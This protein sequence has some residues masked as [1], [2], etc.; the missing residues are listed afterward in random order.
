MLNYMTFPIY[1]LNFTKKLKEI[2]LL[3]PALF[4]VKSEKLMPEITDYFQ[5]LLSS[6]NERYNSVLSETDTIQLK[7]KIM[8]LSI[9]EKID[10]CIFFKIKSHFNPSLT[11][12][13]RGFCKVLGLNNNLTLNGLLKNL[14]NINNLPLDKLKY[15]IKVPC[16][17][18][19]KLIEVEV[20]YWGS[21]KYSNNILHCSNCNHE[22]IFEISKYENDRRG[23]NSFRGLATQYCNCNS[24]NEWR[25][26]L[27]KYINEGIDS[28]EEEL[29]DEIYNNYTNETG[30]FNVL[31]LEQLYKIHKNSLTKTENE[32]L[33]LNPSNFNEMDT[34]LNEMNSRYKK[35]SKSKTVSNLFSHGIIY[36]EINPNMLKREITKYSNGYR[37][38]VNAIESN[39]ISQLYYG[40]MGVNL[41]EVSSPYSI[42]YITN[43]YFKY[44]NF[45][46]IDI[47]SITDYKLNK[48]YFQ[49]SDS[50]I[51]K[52]EYNIFNS[53]AECTLF[54]QLYRQYSNYIICPNISLKTFVN[55]DELSSAFSKDEMRYLKYCIIDFAISDLDGFVV[56]CIELQKGEHH[57]EKEW[58]YKDSLKKRCF[59]F[60][61]IEFAYEY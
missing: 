18:C 28:F 21:D 56:K 33:S 44:V 4:L 42:D 23:Y 36:E 22:F 52:K 13:I 39:E 3:Q 15:N 45:C 60:L 1:Q 5:N 14:V 7:N 41:T 40:N 53:Q 16:V 51:I 37:V 9:E 31:S 46:S 35:S 8:S 49:E 10:I 57:N 26:T 24:C 20:T 11:P 2:I 55:I 29:F 54:K 61:G 6:F 30:N 58:I 17:N 19:K 50:L 32:L 38:L 34:L 43:G 12:S 48:Y 59:E 27:V 25:K 47:E